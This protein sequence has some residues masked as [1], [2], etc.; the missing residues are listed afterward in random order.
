MGLFALLGATMVV[1]AGNSHASAYEVFNNDGNASEWF[2][3]KAAANTGGNCTDTDNG[4]KTA[5]IGTITAHTVNPVSHRILTDYPAL[6]F[7]CGNDITIPGLA[8]FSTNWAFALIPAN[9]PAQ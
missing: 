8:N 5:F 2:I 7:A 3:I 1:A 6:E 9:P 4:A